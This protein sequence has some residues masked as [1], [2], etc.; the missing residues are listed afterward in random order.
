MPSICF[1]QACDGYGRQPESGTCAGET[2]RRR[3]SQV[4]PA[5]LR[6]SPRVARIAGAY[7]K[8]PDIRDT[9]GVAGRCRTTDPLV[10]AQ[11]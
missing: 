7:D 4:S 1:D 8:S 6:V 10:Y 5:R 3:V 11:L 2:T 9:V